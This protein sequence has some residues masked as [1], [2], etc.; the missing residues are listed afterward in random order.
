MTLLLLFVFACALFGSA[1]L[2]MLYR[3]QVTQKL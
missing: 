2:V 3:K 1:I